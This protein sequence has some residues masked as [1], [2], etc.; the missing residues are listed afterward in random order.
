M[1]SMYDEISSDYASCLLDYHSVN[2][3][4][5][6]TADTNPA[7]SVTTHDGLGNSKN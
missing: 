1:I 3:V 2:G 4:S 5:E 7:I 6:E